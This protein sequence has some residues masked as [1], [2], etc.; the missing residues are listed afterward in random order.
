MISK[1]CAGS[2]Q[3]RLRRCYSPSLQPETRLAATL[4]AKGLAA[5]PGVVSGTAYN[6]VDEA[7]EAA[8]DGQ[9][10]ILGALQHQSR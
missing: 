9:D 6:D 5:C 8:E 10:V 3:R 2:I 7:I 4:L 1:R